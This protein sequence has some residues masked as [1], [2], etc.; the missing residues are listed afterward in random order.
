MTGSPARAC[1]AAFEPFTIAALFSAEA[2]A[3]VR[4]AGLPSISSYVVMRAAPL[5]AAHPSVVTAV[6]RSFPRSTFDILPVAW[7]RLS[8]EDA[9]RRTHE[10]VTAWCADAFADRPAPVRAAAE[11]VTLVS[12]V[13]TVGRP[14]A[15]ANQAVPAPDEPWARLW[16]A[17]TTLREHRGDAHVAALV[18]AG[19]GLVES[20][21]LTAAWAGGRVDLAMLRR[22]RRIDDAA[23]AAG[24][25][26]LAARGLLT[27]AGGVTDAGRTL[28]SDVEDAT[29]R[30]SA[31]PYERLGPAGTRRLWQLT[32][33]LSRALIEAGRIPAVTPVGAPWPPPGL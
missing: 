13:D 17:L 27:G 21:V 23:W 15:A 28:R 29:D 31:A 32:A 9:V 16:R 4:D 1:W 8:P 33:E 3:A 22:T 14:L 25:A 5:G 19:L 30:A 12:E 11:I 24:Q 6:F 18:A 10:V 20:E 26:S 2:R 7:T